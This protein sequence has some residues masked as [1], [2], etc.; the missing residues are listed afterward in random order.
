MSDKPAEQIERQDELLQLLYWLEGEGF[1]GTATVAG[2]ARFLAYSE[3]ETGETLAQLLRRGEV[4]HDSSTGEY[5][6]T[7]TGRREAARRFAEEFA[8]LLNQAH[9]ECNDP[10]C[11][12]HTNPGAAAECHAARVHEGH[13]H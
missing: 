10:S 3:D 2:L 7:E 12:C 9:G 8:P 11:D 4:S 6:L 1:G 13:G 5:L